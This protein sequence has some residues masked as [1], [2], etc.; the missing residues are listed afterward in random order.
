MSS[1]VVRYAELFNRRDWDGLRAMLVDDV[2]LD[3]VSRWTRRGRSDV[4]SYFGN[5][6]SLSS[7]RVEPGWLARKQ[8]LAFFRAAPALRPDYVVALS[9]RDDRIASIRDY[10]YVPYLLQEVSADAFTPALVDERKRHAD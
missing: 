5:Y 2:R 4:G 10:R 6:A 7:W 8:V 1:T 3:L 9:T